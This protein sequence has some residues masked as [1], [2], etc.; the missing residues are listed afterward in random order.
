MCCNTEVEMS[1]RGARTRLICSALLGTLVISCG[2]P[3]V[4]AVPPAPPPAAGRAVET[5][6]APSERELAQT[7]EPAP[8]AI[9]APLPQVAPP[10]PGAAPAPATPPA[11]AVPPARRGGAPPGTALVTLPGG[12]GSLT[13]WKS[14]LDDACDK[15]NKPPKCIKLNINYTDSEGEVIDKQPDENCTVESQEPGMGAKVPTSERVRLD[16]IC[17]TSSADEDTKDEGN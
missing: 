12:N 14:A 3:P 16:V 5:T 4:S 10:P 1:A 6:L 13:E 8:E 2:G 15:A 9:P 11:Q 17:D 7:P